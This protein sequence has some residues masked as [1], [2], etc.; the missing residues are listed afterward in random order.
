M[1]APK[2]KGGKG[3]KGKAIA[4][5]GGSVSKGKGKGGKP[6]GK[7]KDNG[8]EKWIQVKPTVLVTGCAGYV[9]TSII[10]KLVS[11][12]YKVRGTMRSVDLSD[13]RVAMMKR[14]FPQVELVEADLLGAEDSFAKAMEGCKYVIHTASPFKLDAKDVQ[15]E[16][17]APAIKGTEAVMR[18]AAKAKIARVVLTSSVAAVG[19]WTKEGKSGKVWTEE[20]WCEDEPDGPV[21]G[22]RVSKTLAEKKAWELSKELGVELAVLNP[23]FVIGPMLSARKDGESVQFMV[24]MLDGTMKEKAAAGQLSGYPKPV[25]DVRD[26]ALAHVRAMEKEEAA[27]KRIL[28]CSETGYTSAKM[29]SLLGDRFKAYPLP[30]ES[31]EQEIEAKF[32]NK[33][34]KEILG[35]SLRPVEVSLRDMAA[36]ALRLGMVE[37]KFIKKAAKGFGKV[38]DIMPDSR[39][40]YLLV[41]VVSIGTPEE[42]RGGDTITEVVVGDDSGLVT[43]RLNGEEIKALGAVGDVVEIRNGAV[44]MTK[45]FIRLIVGKWGKVAKHD[46]DT[47]VTPNQSRDIS[48]TEYELVA[49]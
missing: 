42:G 26:L 18:A 25:T 19:N 32:E 24:K 10:R 15:S 11:D 20:D 22:Y 4:S 7:G 39:S 28:V 27:G 35:V 38:T 37:R 21:T 3:G 49:A 23:G 47:T 13:T 5:K 33:R 40:V 30:T 34:T 41:S 48:S 2:G 1:G 45:G 29:A 43:V 9:A 14:L 17:I 36:A 6:S 12:G 16:L 31:Q 46:G 8:G 44:K